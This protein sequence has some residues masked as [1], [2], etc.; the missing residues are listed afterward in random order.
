MPVPKDAAVLAHK[1]PGAGERRV[2]HQA[3]GR[4]GDPCHTM[5]SLFVRRLLKIIAFKITVE[6]S[7][8][9]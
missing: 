6:D 9:C 5:S 8:S 7:S 1:S 2:E 3:G 4:V